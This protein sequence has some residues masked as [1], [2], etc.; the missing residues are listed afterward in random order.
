MP[1]AGLVS[2]SHRLLEFGASQPCPFPFVCLCVLGSVSPLASFPA[3]DTG[4][5][6][7]TR[8]CSFATT[9]VRPA[10]KAGNLRVENTPRLDGACPFCL[11]HFSDAD[12]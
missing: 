1:Y 2:V 10:K 4:R 7:A 9:L 6:L 8:P 3:L 5:L 11:R 12:G